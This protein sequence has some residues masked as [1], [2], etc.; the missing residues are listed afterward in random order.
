MEGFDKTV[1]SE[2]EHW[3]PDLMRCE[4]CGGKFVVDLHQQKRCAT[5]R[6][7]FC[8]YCGT[9]NVETVPVVNREDN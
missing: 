1:I 8:P 2:M 4:R 5:E 3:M 7:L 9:Q 6:Y